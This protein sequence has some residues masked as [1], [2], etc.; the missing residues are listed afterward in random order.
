MTIKQLFKILPHY[1][2][3]RIRKSCKNCNDIIPEYIDNK[4]LK[5]IEHYKII[6]ISAF[7]D[8]MTIEVCIND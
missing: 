6:K 8:V 2:K 3:F 4:P 1:Q 7:N 5:E